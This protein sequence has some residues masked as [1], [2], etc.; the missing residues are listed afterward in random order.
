MGIVLN[1]TIKTIDTWEMG[2]HE[3]KKT[4]RCVQK[5]IHPFLYGDHEQTSKRV[6]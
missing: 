3:V 4:T 1:F 2:M 5:D 6:I